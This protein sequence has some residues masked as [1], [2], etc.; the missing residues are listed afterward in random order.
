MNKKQRTK[1]NK[2]KKQSRPTVKRSHAGIVYQGTSTH[3]TRSSIHSRVVAGTCRRDTDRGGQRGNEVPLHMRATFPQ[4]SDPINRLL[5]L[6]IPDDE[7][8][9]QQQAQFFSA[10]SSEILRM[11]SERGIDLTDP[12][13]SGRL[14]AFKRDILRLF[15]QEA[16]DSTIGVEFVRQ[17]NV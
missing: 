7:T 13:E 11:H 17:F 4:P 16:P 9:T 15:T 5:H 1:A 2:A 8:N 3:E 14:E 10:V 6:P 12:R